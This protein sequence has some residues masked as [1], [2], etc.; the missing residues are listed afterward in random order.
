MCDRVDRH[1]PGQ[2]HEAKD[3]NHKSLTFSCPLLADRGIKMHKAK[4]VSHMKKRRQ[5]AQPDIQL[6]VTG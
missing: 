5:L 4:G 6:S 2:M 3:A 1:Y